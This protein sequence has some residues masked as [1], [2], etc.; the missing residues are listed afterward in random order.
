[1]AYLQDH[2]ECI[3]TPHH[4][5]DD[6][7]ALGS[8]HQ[9][10]PARQ[11]ALTPNYTNSASSSDFLHLIKYL[12]ESRISAEHRRRVEEEERRLKE[13]ERRIKEEE[14]RLQEEE[15]RRRTEEIR[16]KED[17]ERFAALLQMMSPIASH[18]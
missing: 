12:E 2:A 10:A 17:Y 6:E 18:T 15:N 4:S 14:R 1:M 13:E 8:P 5:D 3:D 9:Q 7:G 11:P 16:R